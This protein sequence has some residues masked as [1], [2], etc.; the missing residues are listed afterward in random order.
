MKD[1]IKKIR[2]DAGL[3]QT[4]FAKALSISRS[5]VCK[6]ESGE[7]NP[8]EQ[9]IKLI[10]QGFSVNDEWLRTGN[11]DPYMPPTDERSEY[12]SDLL[13]NK[14]DEFCEMVIQIVKTYSGL[15]EKS[16]T[17]LRNFAKKLADNTKGRG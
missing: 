17:V 10:Q 3:N 11:G 9:T 8:S 13:E 1:R 4:D 6:M 7:N 16:K 2:V 15:D 14:D 5:A 12:I